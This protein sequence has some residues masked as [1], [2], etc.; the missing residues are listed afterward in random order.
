MMPEYRDRLRRGLSLVDQLVHPSAAR[1]AAGLSRHR[2]FIGAHLACGALALAVLP[3]LLA[4]HGPLS[5]T[6]ILVFAWAL[7]QLPLAMYVSRSGALAR[8]QLGSAVASAGFVAGLAALSG[9]L[10]SPALPFLVLAPLEAALT[11]RRGPVVLT[12]LVCLVLVAALAG[13]DV[14]A[15]MP[16]A[17]EPLFGLLPVGAVATAMALMLASLLALAFVADL[18]AAEGQARG[19]A[20]GHRLL[21]R[22]ARDAVAV[23][24]S[25]GRIASISPSVRG[26]FGLAP[27]ELAGDG[28]F[29]RLHVGDRPAYLKAVSDTAADG[30]ARRLE[31]RLRRGGNRPGE[32]GV[33]DFGWIDFEVMTDAE[34][35][36]VVSVIR[37]I[38]T[39]REMEADRDAARE[40][41]DAAQEARSRFLATVSH[42]LRTPLNAILGFSDLMRKLPQAAADT[43]KVQDY[44]GLIHQSGSHLLQLVNDMLNMARIEAGQFRI[45]VE[46][47]DMRNCLDGCRRMMAAEAEQAGLRLSS[48][49]PLDLGEFT[50][51]PRACR[52][53]ALNLLANAVKFTPAGGRIVLFARKEASGL[54]FGV[55]DTGVGIA[56][57]DLDR[58]TKP[59][60]QASDGTARSHDGAGLGLSVVKGLAEL[61]GGRISLESRVGAGTCVTVYLPVCQAPAAVTADPANAEP[62]TASGAIAAAECAQAAVRRIA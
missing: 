10:A 60:V 26:V 1:D 50:A 25:G 62:A 48:D 38:D 53:I 45:A 32:T 58:V 9:G 16:A 17:P 2:A 24:E 33:S 3:M 40:A 39:R 35:G 29:Q 52:Q 18:R 15:L 21:A 56:G 22:H 57:A 41:A 20:G 28:F 37:D 44:A 19:A 4:L 47:V 8:G 14:A 55:R 13:A 51:D 31:L 12:L 49:I 30:A 27:S 6:A 42:E 61:H 11:R 34:S 54:V 5:P 46:P 59:F 23:H 43:R 7:T 36:R